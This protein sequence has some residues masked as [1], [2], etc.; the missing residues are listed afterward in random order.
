MRSERRSYPRVEKNYSWSPDH[1][2]LNIPANSGGNIYVIA[3]SPARDFETVLERTRGTMAVDAPGATSPITGVLYSVILP[4]IVIGNK[5]AGSNV[6]D[7]APSALDQDGTDDFP[8]WHSFHS[9]SQN[10]PMCIIDS[11]ARRKISKDNL[12]T[13]LFEVIGSGG[14]TEKLRILMRRLYRWNA[15]R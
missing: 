8:L 11:K 4:D 13:V 14:T 2:I 3:H 12:N 7:A 6:Q 1:Y 10:S 9:S 15:S 5:P